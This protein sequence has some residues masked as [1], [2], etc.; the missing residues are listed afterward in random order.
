MCPCWIQVFIS[1]NKTRLSPNFWAVYVCIGVCTC[2][3][4]RA[5]IIQCSQVGS[6]QGQEGVEF[7]EVTAESGSG[8]HRADDDVPQRVS[9]ETGKKRQ[10]CS[11]IFGLY[12]LQVILTFYL[13]TTVLI[14]SVMIIMKLLNIW[15]WEDV[16]L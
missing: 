5:V 12:S 16:K 9:D 15:F 1:S 3:D 11:V 8:Q 2:A 10:T 7:T 4:Q 14:K 6:R 13:G